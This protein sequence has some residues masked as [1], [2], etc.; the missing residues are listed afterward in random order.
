MIYLKLS[1][2]R[3]LLWL[4]FRRNCNCWRTLTGKPATC[5]VKEI[6]L[7]IRLDYSTRSFS[8]RGN[9]RGHVHTSSNYCFLC[10][11]PTKVWWLLRTS[12]E[13]AHFKTNTMKLQVS[14][15]AGIVSFMQE[16]GS[17]PLLCI[18]KDYSQKERNCTVW[19]LRQHC[20]FQLVYWGSTA[21]LELKYSCQKTPS[22]EPSKWK[23]HASETD[24]ELQFTPLI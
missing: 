15:K 21:V 1:E 2:W 24:N 12:W 10:E 6:F 4:H 7:R 18:W 19:H 23:R 13:K 22:L 17:E 9:S 16:S 14:P 20:K 3:T 11:N 5:C 8:L